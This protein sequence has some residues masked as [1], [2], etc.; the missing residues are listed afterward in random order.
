MCQPLQ[1]PTKVRQRMTEAEKV[2]DNE[3]AG[4]SS[5]DL[6][7]HI[8][9]PRALEWSLMLAL[10]LAD[11]RLE[12]QSALLALSGDRLHLRTQRVAGVVSLIH[13]R[14]RIPDH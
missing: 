8:T 2:R 12:V 11:D 4:V 10:M 9:E 5:R 3:T 1:H 13:I 14:A 7:E 6:F